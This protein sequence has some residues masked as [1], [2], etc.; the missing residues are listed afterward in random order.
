[1]GIVS[2][3]P[4]VVGRYVT[5]VIPGE[6]KILTLCEVEVYGAGVLGNQSLTELHLIGSNLPYQGH[7]FHD[8]AT[9]CDPM[10][11]S[12]DATVSCIQLGYPGVN[13]EQWNSSYF[14]NI[15]S[16]SGGR[17]VE[18]RYKCAGT[19]GS[20]QLCPQAI[21]SDTT[22]EKQN[23][24]GVTCQP[25]IRLRGLSI[26]LEGRIEVYHRGSWGT[27]CRNNEESFETS[28]RVACWELGFHDVLHQSRWKTPRAVGKISLKNVKCRGDEK[29]LVFC[30]R[31]N[32][33]CSH[34]WDRY[35][36]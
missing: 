2:C 36:K 8:G 6:N 20:L 31:E 30:N 32:T 4:A 3:K 17:T 28:A 29:S 35:V 33:G 25:Y 14:G 11:S 13:V 7:L 34:Y 27:V 19:E 18:R 23:A 9:F 5:V 10:W 22:C 1:E 16:S 26:P 15:G 24:I 21:G 12:K